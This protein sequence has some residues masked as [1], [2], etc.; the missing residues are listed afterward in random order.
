MAELSWDDVGQEF[1]PA[2]K[3]V[4]E[5][6]AQPHK[7]LGT[8][9]YERFWGTDVDEGP[10]EFIR[11]GS[12][13][14]GGMGGTIAGAAVGGA[15][16]TAVAPGPGTVVGAGLGAMAGGFAGG[17]LGTVAPEGVMEAAEFLGVVEE[18]TRDRLG[19]TDK[20]LGTV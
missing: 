10:M 18:G 19:L 14:V 13:L 16:G 17:M 7:G 4:L 15:A 6:E 8:K 3:K 9:A 20:E 5:M 12:Q 1:D 2:Q 11:L